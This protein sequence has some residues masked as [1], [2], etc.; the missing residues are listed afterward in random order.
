MDD[1]LQTIK[2]V[3]DVRVVTIAHPIWLG[4][5]LGVGLLLFQFA[6]GLMVFFF[7]SLAELLS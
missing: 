1:E 3:F 5:K 6:F 2:Q 7:M 4:V